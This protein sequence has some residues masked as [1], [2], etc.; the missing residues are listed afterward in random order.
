[1]DEC[2]HFCMQIDL[3]NLEFGELTAEAAC[4]NVWFEI[5]ARC[6]QAVCHLTLSGTPLYFLVSVLPQPRQLRQVSK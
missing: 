6:I 3:H 1:M 5:A 2:K 4:Q